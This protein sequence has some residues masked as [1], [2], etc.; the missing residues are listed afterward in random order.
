LLATAVSGALFLLATA[1]VSGVLFLLATAVSGAL[2]LLATA[3]CCAFFFFGLRPRD[4]GIHIT[5][6][7]HRQARLVSF[8]LVL[9]PKGTHSAYHER[10]KSGIGHAGGRRI[11]QTAQICERA[12]NF[13]ANFHAVSL[14]DLQA[15]RHRDL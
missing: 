6:P 4:F 1:A 15:R 9:A 14:S 13:R 3:V 10:A 7:R 12:E 5:D 8:P 2:F 11:R